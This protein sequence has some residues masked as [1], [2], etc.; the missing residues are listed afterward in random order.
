MVEIDRGSLPILEQL[1][2]GPCPQMKEVPSGIQHLKNLK[3][4]DF[5]EMHREF[6]LHLQPD[7]GKD[8]WEVKKVT[9]IR[10]IYRIKGECYQIYKLGELDL[11]ERLQV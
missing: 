11:L 8:Y 3:I 1:E 5:Y 9:T 6:V 10:F 2:I 7:R 4:L